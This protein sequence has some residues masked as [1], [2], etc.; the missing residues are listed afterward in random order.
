MGR[1]DFYDGSARHPDDPVA[2]AIALAVKASQGGTG[3]LMLCADRDQAEAL[4]RR[5]WQVGEALFVPHCLAD[6]PD[7]AAAHVVIAAPDMAPTLQPVVINLRSEP[8]PGEC[9]RVVEVIPVDEPGRVA[10]RERWRA[11][12]AR[13]L[14]LSRI[15]LPAR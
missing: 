12:Q 15:D 14:S 13:G 4:D 9:A 1:V 5:L 6:D 7:A 11:Y 8:V 3:V 2:V 10:A